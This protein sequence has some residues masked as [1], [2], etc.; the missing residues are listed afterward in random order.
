MSLLKKLASETAIY[1]LSS[2][3]GRVLNYG[4]MTFYLTREFTKGEYG[5][6]SDMYAMA[7]LTI[8]LFTYGMETAFFRFATKSNKKDEAF[9]TTMI[10]HIITT[11]I[12]VTLLILAATPIANLLQYPGKEIYVIWFALI[13]G[14]D[15]LIAIP[16]A[17]LRLDNRPIRFA[18][19]KIASI[20]INLFAILFFL[21][22]CPWLLENGYAWANTLYDPSDRI[23]YVFISNFLASASMFFLLIPSIF[24]ISKKGGKAFGWSDFK[25]YKDLWKEM[26]IY[27]W[28]LVFVGFASLINEVLDRTL[29]KY[30]LSDDIEYN[31]TQVGIYS[32]CYKLAILLNLFIQAFRYAAEPFFFRNADRKD[33]GPVYAKV[34]F[35][36]SIIG[37]LAF[38]SILLYIDYFILIIGADFREGV[39]IVPILLLANLFL[40]LTFNFSIWYKL[41]DMTKMGALIAGT[42]AIITISLNL[43][44]IK[45]LGYVG[46][47]W[48]TLACYFVMCLMSYFLGQKYRPIPYPIFKIFSYILLA[49]SIYFITLWVEPQLNNQFIKIGFHTILIAGFSVLVYF[50]EKDYLLSSS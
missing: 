29:I 41:S 5:V 11:S 33:S 46:S 4:I 17:R 47:A 21:E 10:S 9:S 42:G 37:C 45:P 6:V 26:M 1:G 18:V 16:F 30:F 35:A 28:P 40:G 20:F 43:I 22:G 25:F 50:R 32:A 39:A 38:L 44:L 12:F 36:F 49:I 13:M 15:T 23:K 48:A 27:A 24:S 31:I 8:V 7:A 2:I 14:A 3:L 34:A 19:I